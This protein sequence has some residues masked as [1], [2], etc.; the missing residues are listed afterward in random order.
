MYFYLH[1]DEEPEYPSSELNSHGPAVVGWRCR[2]NSTLSPKEIILRFEKPAIICRIQ[3]LA[4]QCMIPERIE[5]WIHHSTRG[6][7]TTPS[8]QTYDFL[9]FIALSDNSATNYKS[10]ELQSVPVGPKKGTHLKLRFGSPYP[11]DLNKSNQVRFVFVFFY[12][13]FYRANYTGK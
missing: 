2:A 6:A 9:G 4:H 11:N 1:L 7:P 10:R 3:V 5:L 12:I 8:S 13:S